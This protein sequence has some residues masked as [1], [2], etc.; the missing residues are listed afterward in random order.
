MGQEICRQL[1]SC[2]YAVAVGFN[3]SQKAAHKLVSELKGS[4]A[5]ASGVNLDITRKDSVF[6][7]VESANKALGGKVLNLVY[8]AG[9]K[10]NYR[11]IAKTNWE[12]IAVQLD[13]LVKGCWYC[14][15]ALRGQMEETGFGRI[16]FVNSSVTW[17][18]PPPSLVD[19]VIAR[20]SQQGM[21][22]AAAIELGS[23]VITINC[24]SPALTEAESIAVIPEI[25]KRMVASQNPLRRLATPTDI[26]N[27]VL[28]LLRPESSYLNGVDIPVAGGAL[29]R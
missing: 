16:I 26:A 2:G 1:A 21:M 28:F 19:Y 7:A 11:P 29:M 8:T 15:E 13:L 22:K 6:Q 12:D 25:A 24:V 27:A 20:Y 14:L 4:G 10:F 17:G 3:S 5:A 9:A 23:K 18:M